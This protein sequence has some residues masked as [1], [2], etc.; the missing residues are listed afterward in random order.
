MSVTDESEWSPWLAEVGRA[1]P[2]EHHEHAVVVA[3][4]PDDET[5][6]VS[7]LMQ[8][9]HDHGTA[10]TLV[11]A[12]DGEA[13]FPA[14]SAPERAVLGETRRAE[15]ADSLR[16]Q[17]MTG[18]DV[19]WLGLPDSRLAEHTA[20]LAERL[21]GLLADANVCFV[22]WPDDPHPDHKA[23]AEVALAA[24]PVTAHRWSYPIWM[25]H[26]MRPAD[27]PTA[28]TFG[29]RMT[30]TQR[31][32]KAAGLAAFTSQLKPG[33]NGE[34]PILRPDMLRHFE[35]DVEVVY[36]QPPARSAPISR[37]AELYEGADDP[38]DVAG[39]WYE[40]R[41]RAVL[42]AS[43]PGERYGTAV[44]P[45]CGN[46]ALTR[47]L[48]QRCDR[49]LAF[50]PVPAAVARCAALGLPNVDVTTGTLPDDMP[51]EP[52]DLVVFSEI[53]YYLGDDDLESTVDNAVA[54]LRPGGHIVAV[55]WLPWAAEA[56]R[57]GM[58]AH[59]TLLA[60]PALERLV[61]HVDERFVL[62][63]VGRR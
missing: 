37:F 39:K 58:A 32:R 53:L 27:V 54:A 29:Y 15:L 33:P 35:R 42:L 63:V 44:E 1:F 24:A 45:A 40:R 52:A 30:E 61:E 18:V 20:E 17:G 49:V 43:L 57:D 10:V 6:G 19:H 11:V 47:A 4:H 41:K 50:D 26:W 51:R 25:W 23:V 16:A 14:L 55:H 62:H 59:Q 60:H 36:R 28:R 3:A 5:L 8:H 13:A 56:P 2:D 46:G 34:E 38:W 7:G 48:A 12:T 21:S 9:L 31:H 22:P